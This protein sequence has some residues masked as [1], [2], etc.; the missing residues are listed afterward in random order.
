[1]PIII[2]KINSHPKYLNCFFFSLHSS[3]KRVLLLTLFR[4]V[5]HHLH[6]QDNTLYMMRDIYHSNLLN[7]EHADGGKRK[8]TKLKVIPSSWKN[9]RRR[10]SNSDT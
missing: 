1:M 4:S 9:V 5:F 10:K 7:P 8:G 3:I 2:I 6:A